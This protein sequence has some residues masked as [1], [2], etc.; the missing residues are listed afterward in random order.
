[1]PHALRDMRAAFL[2]RGLSPAE[3]LRYVSEQGPEVCRP[4]FEELAATFSESRIDYARLHR[5]LGLRGSYALDRMAEALLQFHNM[6]QRIPE[7]LDLLIPRLRKEVRIRREMRANISN[8]RRQLVIVAVMPFLVVLFFRAVAP[9]YAG[10]YAR[11]LG[12]LILIL[13][14]VVDVAVYLGASAVVRRLVNPIPYRRSVPERR[15][16]VAPEP[17]SPSTIAAGGEGWGNG[18]GGGPVNAQTV[19]FIFAALG[20]I[21]LFFLVG[22][23][24]GRIRLSLAERPGTLSQHETDERRMRLPLAVRLAKSITDALPF[25]RFGLGDDPLEVHLVRAGNPYDSPIQFYQRKLAYMG[26]FSIAAIVLGVL[27]GLPIPLTLF[28]ALIA[29]VLGLVSPESLIADRIRKRRDELRR[30]MAFM[31]DRVGFAVM[32]YGTFQETLSRMSTLIEPGVGGSFN[33]EF[34]ER[35]RVTR[36]LDQEFAQVPG[37][38]G[39]GDGRYGR[40]ALRAVPQSAGD[41]SFCW[42][43]RRFQ[44]RATEA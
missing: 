25:G 12:Q 5:L 43:R 26:L 38:P 18:Q 8:P 21:G 36:Q 28:V 9:E 17:A 30:E 27:I 41:A 22:G 40:G 11:P 13:A 34:D 37:G 16:S 32:A 4:D 35:A 39:D 24:T 31:L 3:A 7:I 29:G 1:M 42:Y 2:A 10:F 20:A 23:I 14:F 19:N 15:R 6:P 44:G 33:V